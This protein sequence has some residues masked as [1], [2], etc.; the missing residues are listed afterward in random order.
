MSLFNKIFKGQEKDK[1]HDCELL[2]AP[3]TGE[4]VSLEKIPDPVFSSG[5]LGDGCGIIPHRGEVTSPVD[6]KVMIV[7]DTKHSVSIEAHDGRQFLIHIGIDTVNMNGN[8]FDV[9]VKVGDDVKV[10]QN[11]MKCDL[12]KIIEAGYQT[13]SAFLLVNSSEYKEINFKI[14]EQ[15]NLGEIVGNIR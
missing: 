12:D 9:L 5:V 4:Y 8:G 1:K 3:I 11:I 10:G 13:T 6:G 15:I 2:Y 7:S 14:D